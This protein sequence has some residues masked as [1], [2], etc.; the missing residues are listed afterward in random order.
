ME[1]KLIQ[2]ELPSNLLANLES[3]YNCFFETYETID[4][5]GKYAENDIYDRANDFQTDMTSSIISLV[6]AGFKPQDNKVYKH[7][8]Q[9]RCLL[10]E[11]TMNKPKWNSFLV[12]LLE[13]G[14][15]KIEE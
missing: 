1:T 7:I 8:Y 2:C 10:H 12:K 13:L 14:I 6:L 15:L 3:A 5:N 4:G 9:Y 11:P